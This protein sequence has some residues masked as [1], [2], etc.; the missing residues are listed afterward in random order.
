MLGGILIVLL[1]STAVFG[2]NYLDIIDHFVVD[3]SNRLCIKTK[4]GS[5]IF[6]IVTPPQVALFVDDKYIG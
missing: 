2:Q 6:I 1:P 3:F 5:F 4:Q